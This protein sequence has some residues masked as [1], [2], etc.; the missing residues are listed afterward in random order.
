M[1]IATPK[2]AGHRR[3][4][5]LHGYKARV[6][7]GSEGTGPVRYYVE[8]TTANVRDAA[9]LGWAPPP[10][11]GDVHGGSAFAGGRS[12]QAVVARSGVPC[13]VHTGTWCESEA[14]ARLLA[15]NAAVRRMGKVS[16]AWMR[17]CGL[18]R[19]RRL[20]QG[21]IAGPLRRHRLRPP[22]HDHLAARL[23]GLTQDES[24]Q[25]TPTTPVGGKAD[26]HRLL[27]AQLSWLLL[28]SG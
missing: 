9:M 10:E 24:A 20:G 11:P 21:R 12:E 25:I 17:S 19:M 6:T 16:G 14:L 22:T 4:R 5:P 28:G 3:R 7:T 18:R 13:M 15:R 1:G 23:G 27:G 8:V 2:W 26:A